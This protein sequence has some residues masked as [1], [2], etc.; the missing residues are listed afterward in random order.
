M[1]IKEKKPD[2]VVWDDQKGY[3]AKELTYGSNVGAPAI[4]L[5]DVGGWKK[6]Q[7]NTLNKHFSKK[8]EELKE[9]F[10]KLIDEVNWNELVYKSEYNFIP[11]VGETYHLYIRDNDTT[12]LSLIDPHSWNKKHIGSFQLDSNQKWLKTK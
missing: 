7:A 3:Y 10:E 5:D 8:Y 2:L 1:E 6:N 12:F 4:K 9:K 11:V